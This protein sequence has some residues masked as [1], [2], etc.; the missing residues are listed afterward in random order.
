[1][2]PSFGADRLTLTVLIDAY[3]EE[4]VKG[5]KRVFMKFL[6][7]VAPVKVAVF[8]LLANKENLV[9]KA[10]DLYK[11]L[12]QEINGLVVFDD[13]GNIGK[14]Y[15]AQDEIGTPVSYT[16]LTLPTIYSV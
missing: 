4:E 8:P 13:R 5:Q 2:E 15:F 3:S 14:R 10:K 12:K 6:P 7:R 11:T 1:M 9:K 16:H